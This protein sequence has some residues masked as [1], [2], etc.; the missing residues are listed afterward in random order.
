M[1]ENMREKMASITFSDI[2]GFIA[3]LVTWIGGIIGFYYAKGKTSGKLEAQTESMEK[4]I[5]S[6]KDDQNKAIGGLRTHVDKQVNDI[7]TETKAQLKIVREDTQEYF[8]KI[9]NEI[10]KIHSAMLDADGD[11]KY[12]TSKQHA[13]I[14]GAH[15]INSELHFETIQKEMS[16]LKES[17]GYLRGDFQTLQDTIMKALS[18]VSDAKVK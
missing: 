4:S 13:R 18:G 17:Q 5:N 10:D 12:L 11:V 7:R 16:E 1:Y 3:I 9:Q 14:C 2:L 6:I 8:G 15:Q